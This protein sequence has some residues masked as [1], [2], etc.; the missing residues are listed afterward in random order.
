MVGVIISGLLREIIERNKIAIAIVMASITCTS[1]LPV[2]GYCVMGVLLGG[3]VITRRDHPRGACYWSLTVSCA[4]T[5]RHLQD[6]EC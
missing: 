6:K 5:R 1:L 2:E 3:L 4:S